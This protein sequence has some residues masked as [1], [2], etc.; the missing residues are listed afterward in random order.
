MRVI[1][2]CPTTPFRHDGERLARKACA[3]HFKEC[4]AA[5]HLAITAR[6][7]LSGTMLD[8]RGETLSAAR[9]LGVAAAYSRPARRAAQARMGKMRSVS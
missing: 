3:R 9:C 2:H 8:Q 6:G 4:Y 5:E 7:M 1:K